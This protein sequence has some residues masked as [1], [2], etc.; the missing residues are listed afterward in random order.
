MKVFKK[1][2]VFR[3]SK[4]W[5]SANPEGAVSGNVISM[6]R[7]MAGKRI[8]DLGCATGSYCLE[9]AK[10]GF[11]CTGAE[12]N[13]EY[14]KIAVSRGVKTV[15]IKD[16]LPFGDKSFDTVLLIEVLEHVPD[17]GRLLKE[18]GRVAKK[19]VIITVPDNSAFKELRKEYLTYEHML[20]QD[21]INFFTKESLTELLNGYF[22]RCEID[23][24]DPICFHRML[25]AYIRKFVSLMYRLG[26]VK[27]SV[28]TRLYAECSIE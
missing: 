20:E 15:L 26:L 21:H 13:E 25:P 19:N 12:T 4:S 14:V 22:K 17:P 28:F 18:A 16:K 23:E 2:D 9:L 10:L 1:E 5:Y 7:K 24:G 6:C 3:D 8:L 11:D 27:S